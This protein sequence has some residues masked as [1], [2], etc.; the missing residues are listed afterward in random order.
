MSETE[1]NKAALVKLFLCASRTHH[2]IFENKVSRFGV[3]RSQHRMLMFLSK[4]QDEPTSQKDIA[5]SFE[6]SA[7][8]VA[9]A[10]KKLEDEGF[11]IRMQNENDNRTNILALTEKGQEIVAA[12]RDI[13]E[14]LDRAMFDGFCDA[15]IAQFSEY[16]SRMLENVKSFEN[17]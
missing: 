3:H 2:R 5:D 4:R 17:Q 6:I 10:V 14:E 11:I 16:F 12:T 7:A 15:E 13:I 9:V 8:A 1:K